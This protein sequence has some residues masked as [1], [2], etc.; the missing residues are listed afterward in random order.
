MILEIDQR[1]Y[2]SGE[3]ISFILP[4]KIVDEIRAAAKEPGLRSESTVAYIADTLAFGDKEIASPVIAGLNPSA[5][6]PL[7]PFLPN[8]VE[9]LIRCLPVGRL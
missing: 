2:L 9:T 4:Q 8:K 3:S 1:N 6:E 5:T 7:G